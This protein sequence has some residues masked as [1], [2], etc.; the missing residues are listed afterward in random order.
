MDGHLTC[1]TR[2]PKS[3]WH[4]IRI[5]NLIGERA[6]RLIT[7]FAKMAGP[8]VIFDHAMRHLQTGTWA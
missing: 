8:V 4:F 6:W 3:H 1:Q 5:S 2:E 7:Q